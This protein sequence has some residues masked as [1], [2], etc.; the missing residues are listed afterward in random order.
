[1]SNAQAKIIHTPHFN[2]GLAEKQEDSQ[3]NFVD[4]EV[5]EGAAFLEDLAGQA[6]VQEQLRLRQKS[7][8]AE[9]ALLRQENSWEQILDM[10]YPLEDK[11]PELVASE[12]DMELR[13]ELAFV[14]GQVNRFD[15]AVREYEVCLQ[16]QPDNYF[17]NSG[18]AYTL[19]NSLYAAQNR[20]ILLTPDGKKHRAEKAHKH[21]EKAQ[22]IRPEGVTNY[23][24]QGMLYKNL[25]NKPALGLPLFARAV[26]NWRGYSPQ[27][28]KAR[29]QEHK[30]YIKALYNLGSCR[31]KLNQAQMA[32]KNIQECIQED[33]KHY[34]SA[35]NKYFALG[36]VCYSL[37]EFSQAREALEF[38]ATM[39]DVK[40]G[41]YVYEMLGRVLLSLE[42]NE[43]ALEAVR[44]V[45]FKLRKPYVRWTEADIL[46]AVGQTQE[47]VQ[48]LTHA[49]NKDR[50]SRH[51]TLIRLCRIHFGQKDYQQS[52][53]Q[54]CEADDFHR[55][56]F[57]SPDA[58][59][60]FWQSACHLHL[61][62][63]EQARQKAQ[64]LSD[65]SP[66]YPFLKK[67]VKAIEKVEQKHKV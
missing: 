9:M 35:V 34:I 55:Q 52:L 44:K 4:N 63:V 26:T 43:K 14:L 50:R 62:E 23:Y 6:Q 47:A 32:L 19:Y 11:A 22:E 61:N 59:A 53:H 18:L 33:Q 31:L 17:A 41:D 7:C 30:N 1:M 25:Q 24:R 54:A 20:E 21:F 29:H 37:G 60:L 48:V 42:E 51:K 28:Q 57:N 65:F 3:E 45:P 5:Q 49:L 27:Q 13:M 67:L 46:V 39:A 36:K 66:G 56:T 64:D 58:D 16:V 40:D 15:E 12:L 38:A 2:S 10:F 8:M